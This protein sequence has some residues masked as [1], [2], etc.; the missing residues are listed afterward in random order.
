[1]AR[2][3]QV[4]LRSD[5]SGSYEIEVFDAEN[6]KAIVLCATGFGMNRYDGYH[7]F[8]D[9][10]EKLS[11]YT[12]VLVELHDISPDGL[13][14]NPLSRQIVRFNKLLSDYSRADTP[15]VLVGHSMGCLAISKS[16]ADGNHAVFLAPAVRDISRTLRNTLLSREGTSEDSD[17]T[18]H[19]KRSDGSTSIVPA[20]FWQ[21]ASQLN[22]AELYEE[23][24]TRLTVHVIVAEEDQI[25]K[26]ETADLQTMPFQSITSIPQAD[27][28]FSGSGRSAMLEEVQI[29]VDIASQK[30]N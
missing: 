30:E 10:A 8:G 13:T 9:I 19:A 23:S 22:I 20:K 14:V 15:V 24:T 12:V 18:M 21:E 6:P 16:A 5:D 26:A 28:D 25:L 17:G 29:L 3:S 1:M 7:L 27:H 2:S 4:T 11:D